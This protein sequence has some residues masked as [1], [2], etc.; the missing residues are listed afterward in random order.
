MNPTL[1]IIVPVYKVEL[2]IHKCITSIL[3]QTFTDF[4]LILIDDGSPDNCG[5]ICDNYA[6]QDNRIIVIHQNN[7]GLSAARNSGLDIAKGEYITFVD[8]DDSIAINTY[9][10]NMEVLLNDN[11][12]DVLEYPYY[13]IFLGE[14]T[15]LY[16]DPSQHLYGNQEIFYYWVVKSNKR[17]NV[18]DKIFKR[19][20]FSTLRFP[21][22]AVYEDLYLLPDIVENVYHLYVSN[23]GS[24]LYYIRHDSISTKKQTLQNSLNHCDSRLKALKK[25]K[26]YTKTDKESIIYYHWWLA[27]FIGILKD[28]PNE[29]LNKYIIQFQNI[30]YSTIHILT[31][32]LT[33][34]YKIKLT[35][36]KYF[37]IKTYIYISNLRFRQ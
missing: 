4:E 24:Y 29:G 36:I 14:K 2:Y 32:K 21:K 5:A 30:N 22:G 13:K 9:Y 33:L 19:E 34:I 31:S 8:S 25:I 37:G 26:E 35:F 11:S 20:I 12:I 23:K 6:K 1:S 17:T 7:Q 15:K 3:N 10:D 28:F 16:D 27:E 18:W